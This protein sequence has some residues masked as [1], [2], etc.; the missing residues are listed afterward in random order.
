MREIC[1]SGSMRGRRKRTALYRACV[2]LYGGGSFLNLEPSRIYERVRRFRLF[3]GGPTHA[4]EHLAI[5]W[6]VIWPSMLDTFCRGLST[7]G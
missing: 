4:A 5:S 6:F 2:L 7:S 3:C 1:T